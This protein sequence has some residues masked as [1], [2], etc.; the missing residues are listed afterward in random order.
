MGK[1]R[2]EAFKWIFI[3][4]VILFGICMVLILTGVIDLSV[5]FERIEESMPPLM[6]NPE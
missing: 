3:I 6:S 1:N 4:T 2:E 5:L